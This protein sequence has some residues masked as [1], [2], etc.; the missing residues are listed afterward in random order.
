MLQRPRIGV[1]VFALLLIGC[2]LAS[3]DESK[4]PESSTSPPSRR[5]VKLSSAELQERLYDFSSRF[6]ARVVAA[7]DLIRSEATEARVRRASV[8]WKILAVE[9]S[10]EAVF[11][12]E[13]VAAFVDVW[14]LSF[15]LYDFL[16]EGEGKDLLGEQ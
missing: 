8:H 16:R 13:P 3:R 5:D 2:R 14:A 4:T 11:Q 6:A 9:Y 15:Q 1:C 7:A 10:R 12:T